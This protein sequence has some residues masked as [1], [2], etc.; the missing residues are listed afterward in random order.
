MVDSSVWIDVLGNRETRQTIAFHQLLAD[1]QRVIAG[2]LVIAEVLQGTRSD[3][4]FRETLATLEAFEPVTISGT[5][6]AIE[7]ARSY[8]TLRALGI[9]PRKTVDTL[10][11]TRCILDRIPLLYSDRDFDPFVE[12]LGL[13]SALDASGV[14]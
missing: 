4:D 14:N 12:H 10:I 9:T 11:A 5:R 8:R 1:R 2:D 7:A 3:R 6:V 13:I